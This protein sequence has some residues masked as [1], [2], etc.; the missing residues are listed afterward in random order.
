[1]SFEVDA[2]CDYIKA[3][4]SMCCD[5]AKRLDLDIRFETMRLYVTDGNF[6]QEFFYKEL[7]E[8]EQFLKGYKMGK[9]A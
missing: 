7:D 3:R 2:Y 5:L 9:K 8:L 4:L 6:N 1:M